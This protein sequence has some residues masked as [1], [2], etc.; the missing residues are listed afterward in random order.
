MIKIDIQEKFNR[1]YLHL[2]AAVFA[3]AGLT[4]Y[5]YIYFWHKPENYIFSDVANYQNIAGN[6]ISG[7]LTQQDFFQPIGTSIVTALSLQMGDLSYLSFL[8]LVASLLTL[9]FI[10]KTTE[11]VASKEIAFL[12]LL[13]A[14][15]H[16]P[17]I[18]ISGVYLSECFYTLFIALFIYLLAKN[19][20]PWS[21]SV[22]FK[23]GVTFCIGLLFKM[24]LVLYLPILSLMMYLK[25]KQ[26]RSVVYLL[27]FVAVFLLAHGLTVYKFTNKFQPSP[28]NGGINFVIGKCPSKLNYDSIGY[29]WYPNLFVHIDEGNN[30]NGGTKHWGQAFTDSSYYYLQGL[31]CIANNPMALVD[32]LRYIPYLFFDNNLWPS[33]NTQIKHN[34]VSRNYSLFFTFFAFPAVLISILILLKKENRELF[35]IWALPVFSLF[36]VAFLFWGAVRLRIPFDIVLLP[37]ALWG[38]QQASRM[39]YPQ[40]PLYLTNMVLAFILILNM[41]F[42][43]S[44]LIL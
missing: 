39:I 31:K 20:Y 7:N 36:I 19:K 9:F 4:R 43:F 8:Q 16:Y 27:I 5:L 2:A 37:M 1:Y 21:F 12:T 33:L 18:F 28:S 44:G 34:K 35:I 26:S 25:Y 24:T 22:V 30:T 11:L 29:S 10:W 6:I 17:F 13:W 41:I 38:W 14:S 32:S 15:F 3:L 23:L 40:S 42:V